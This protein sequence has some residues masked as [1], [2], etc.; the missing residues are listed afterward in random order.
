VDEKV[1]KE[2]IGDGLKKFYKEINIQIINCV[3]LE[4]KQYVGGQWI[5]DVP[6]LFFDLKIHENTHNTK[7]NSDLLT[8]FFGY[9]ININLI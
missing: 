9:E 3:I 5:E 1:I 7:I 2:K 4:R 8:I 6:A